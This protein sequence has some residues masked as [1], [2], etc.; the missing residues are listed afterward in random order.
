MTDLAKRLVNRVQLTTDGHKAHPE[1][2]EETF[3]T[4]FGHAQLV[5]IYGPGRKVNLP[6]ARA[7]SCTASKATQIR[8]M[9]A[10]HIRRGKI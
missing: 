7:R 9:S 6:N 10:R 8:S 2:V 1:A 3:E 4:E 5:K